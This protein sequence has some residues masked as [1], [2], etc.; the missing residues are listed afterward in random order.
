MNANSSPMTIKSWLAVTKKELRTADIRTAELDA[1]VLLEDCIGISR[2]SIL[3]HPETRL[4]SPQITKL[5]KQVQRRKKHEPLAYIR[6]K[7]EF[8]GREFIVN[9]YTLEPRPETETM[10]ELLKKRKLGEKVVIA[11]IGTGSGAIAII[12]QLELPNST[13]LATDISPVC[14]KITNQ[15]SQSHNVNIKCF[16]GDLLAPLVDQKVDVLL[17]NL[18][19][20]PNDFGINKAALHEPK[21]AIFG[22]P[23]GLDL[24]RK[25]FVQLNEREQKPLYIFTESLPFQHEKLAE[26]AQDFGYHA[27]DQEDFIQVFSS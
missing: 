3:A 1:L 4:T 17:C 9:R 16:Q 10:I 15:N 23:D 8:Y 25:L 14:T 21:L 19:Y 6:G 22:G 2:A 20:V 13:V 26:I 11:D 18:P 24:Y 7:T 5:T 27:I 12:A